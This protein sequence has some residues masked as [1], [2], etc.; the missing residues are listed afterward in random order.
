[1]K[2]N[3]SLTVLL[4]I[5]MVQPAIYA[6]GEHKEHDDHK[7]HDDHKHSNHSHGGKKAIGKG[8]AII[9]VSQKKGFRLSKQAINTLRLKLNTVNGA[10]FEINKE[11]LVHSKNL[12]G[13]YR[14]RGGY[15]KFLPV[16]IK[17][18]KLNK[19]LVEVKGLSFGDQIVI[20]GV[21]LLRVTDIYSTDKSEYG[22]AH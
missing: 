17:K 22:H 6:A 1:M 11:T 13:V 12:K 16:I 19:L 10:K 15:F 5:L 18:E 7:G 8:K 9:E 20:N 2:K 21:S 4:L 14:F 3:I